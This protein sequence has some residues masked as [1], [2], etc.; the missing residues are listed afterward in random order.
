VRD[1][2]IVVSG[3]LWSGLTE[4]IIDLQR[5]GQ[6]SAFTSSVLLDELADVLR[7]AP[8]RDPRAAGG[9]VTSFFW[10]SPANSLEY[11]ARGNDVAVQTLSDV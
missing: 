3:L 8:R 6:A 7:A 10:R 2:N 5:A 1:T 4:R 11:G 9:A